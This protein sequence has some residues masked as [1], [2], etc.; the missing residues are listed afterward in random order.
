MKTNEIRMVDN[1]L[2]TTIW[3]EHAL[4]FSSIIKIYVHKET[5]AFPIDAAW[6]CRVEKELLFL[7]GTKF[8]KLG[9]EKDRSIRQKVV[10][11]FE[12]IV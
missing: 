2:S 3:K 4:H 8:K 5:K 12:M 1:I 10:P 9:E 11:V 7:P 6:A